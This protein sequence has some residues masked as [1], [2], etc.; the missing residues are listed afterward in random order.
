MDPLP[1]PTWN[2]L[3]NALRD[4]FNSQLP[5]NPPAG[6]LPNPYLPNQNRDPQDYCLENWL[7]AMQADPGAGPGM[8][9]NML[10]INDNGTARFLTEFHLYYRDQ[11]IFMDIPPTTGPQRCRINPTTRRQPVGNEAPQG[12]LTTVP[13][14]QYHNVSNN[15]PFPNDTDP[16][17]IRLRCVP[18]PDAQVLVYDPNPA[19]FWF[20]LAKKAA[21]LNIDAV[22]GVQQLSIWVDVKSLL[23]DYLQQPNLLGLYYNPK[24][25]FYEHHQGEFVDTSGTGTRLKTIPREFNHKSPRFRWAADFHFRDANGALVD[26]HLKVDFCGMMLFGAIHMGISS[27]F[28]MLDHMV[29][30]YRDTAGGLARC[31][32]NQIR[33]SFHIGPS[34]CSIYSKGNGVNK[35]F[36][37]SYRRQRDVINIRNDQARKNASRYCMWR[38]A[39]HVAVHPGA[40][41]GDWPPNADPKISTCIPPGALPP[42]P[43]DDK[44]KRPLSAYNLFFRHERAVI[45]MHMHE[46][47]NPATSKDELLGNAVPV[48]RLPTRTVAEHRA[49]VRSV[50]NDNPFH[51]DSKTRAHRKSHGKI[52]FTDLVKLVAAR[53]KRADKETKALYDVLSAEEKDK[54]TVQ[55]EAWRAEEYSPSPVPTK[56]IKAVGCD[57]ELSA[58]DVDGLFPMPELSEDVPV[59]GQ[60]GFARWVAREDLL[61]RTMFPSPG[62]LGFARR[63]AEDLEERK[64]RHKQDSWTARLSKMDAAVTKSAVG[65]AEQQQQQ[66]PPAKKAR[67]EWTMKQ[68]PKKLP[69]CDEDDDDFGEE[70]PDESLVDPITKLI[71]LMAKSQQSLKQL[72]D[73]D[74]SQGLPASHSQTMVKTSRSRRQ[75]LEGKIMKKWDG[76]P[77]IEFD[78]SGEEV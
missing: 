67:T 27:V 41:H 76:S 75:L 20:V 16:N 29:E 78:K 31:G 9:P 70:K 12:K 4:E 64:K 55:Y 61:Q 33:I 24:Y 8:L 11:T 14:V 44:P 68:Q 51:R 74:K 5:F 28:S 13:G 42:P 23:L 10:H 25:C 47:Q 6:I 32:N 73:Y 66:Q 62:Q 35:D 15:A 38:P 37:P 69:E 22:P 19:D 36:I 34:F 77:M 1:P 2:T 72:Q 17:R 50:L 46:A 26:R 48:N 39:D 71:Q 63:V 54:Y 7:S 45:L 18:Q 49:A 30:R 43:T 56:S 57:D 58:E 3:E 52:G 53:W 60:L 40:L 21:D 59:L 65:A